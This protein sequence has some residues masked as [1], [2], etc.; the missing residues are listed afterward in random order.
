[1]AAARRVAAE[2]APTLA[3]DARIVSSPSHRAMETAA[4]I[5][6]AAGIAAIAVDERWREAHFGM[7]E[8][9]TFEELTRAAPDLAQRLAAGETGID[10]PGGESAGALTARVAAA[11]RDL[12]AAAQDTVVVSHAGPL[13]IAIGLARGVPPATIE[14]PPPGAVIRL[15]R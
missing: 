14:L 6:H 8:G 11:W 2:L 12:M 15:R 9:L 3:A 7:A 10:W 13:R 4:R 5:A 1:M